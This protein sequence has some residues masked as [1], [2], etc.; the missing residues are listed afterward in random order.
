MKTRKGDEV[1]QQPHNFVRTDYL[2]MRLTK[3]EERLD[4]IEQILAPMPRQ[5]M[6]PRTIIPE[7]K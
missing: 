6:Q 3:I 5:P 7:I 2:E 4:R 1:E